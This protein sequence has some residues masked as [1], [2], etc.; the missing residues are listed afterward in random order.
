VQRHHFGA[1]RGRQ[2]QQQARNEDFQQNTH[3]KLND[4]PKLFPTL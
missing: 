4:S 3:G 2:H 1:Y